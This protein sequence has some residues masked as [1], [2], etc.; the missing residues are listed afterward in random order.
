MQLPCS[1]PSVSPFPILSPA[2]LYLLACALSWLRWLA[3]MKCCKGSSSRRSLHCLYSSS[4][5][6][7]PTACPPSPTQPS[8]ACPLKPMPLS[9]SGNRIPP[10]PSSASPPSPP[11]N[12]PR[13]PTLSC[14]ILPTQ[15]NN[16]PTRDLYVFNPP[17]PSSKLKTF[18][19]VASPILP[20]PSAGSGPQ[21]LSF[22]SHPIPSH[23]HP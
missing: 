22:P 10:P 5:T 18:R 20:Y 8:P 17:S 4:E 13:S 6:Q 3:L 16:Q 19:R 21:P 2:L 11:V 15:S 7:T 12:S 23:L 9:F 14:P 1:A